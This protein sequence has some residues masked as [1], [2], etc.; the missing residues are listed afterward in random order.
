MGHAATGTKQA[1]WRRRHREVASLAGGAVNGEHPPG[2]QPG[3]TKF[4]VL[5]APGP[6]SELV[7]GVEGN[8]ESFVVLW[9]AATEIPATNCLC[10]LHQKTW[11]EGPTWTSAS[12]L[13]GGLRP[14]AQSGS[15]AA[16]E[17][18]ATRPWAARGLR[19]GTQDGNLRWRSSPQFEI[20]L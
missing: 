19:A 16:P 6:R 20:I 7:F 2:P 12:P 8:L 14:P 18:P 1:Q 15:G 3:V 4:G 10:L 11:A 5:L 13:A 9:P 17:T